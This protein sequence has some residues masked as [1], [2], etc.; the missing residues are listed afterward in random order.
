MAQPLVIGK[1]YSFDSA[2]P[3]IL[4]A[5]FNNV[6]LK[7]VLDYDTAKSFDNVDVKWR[8]VYP[9]LSPPPSDNP[10]N[11]EYY[12]FRSESGA[13]IVVAAPWILG[14]T[15][16]LIEDITITVSI[17]GTSVSDV[18]V[19][20]SGLSALGFKDFKISHS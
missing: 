6:R 15:I 8:Q 18:A 14:D 17:Y 7:A 16:K 1:V 12:L 13:S 5:E 11:H 3:G 2:A 4:G 10:K 19:I 9:V 20:S